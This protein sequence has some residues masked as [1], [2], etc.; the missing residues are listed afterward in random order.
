MEQLRGVGLGSRSS[1]EEQLCAAASNSNFEKPQL[2]GAALG[3]SFRTQKQLSASTLRSS[4]RESLWR[5][6][7]GNT[8]EA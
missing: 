7:L 1:F 3:T 8:F 4:F 5:I 6:A 2:W